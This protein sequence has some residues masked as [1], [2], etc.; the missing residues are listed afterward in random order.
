M[1]IKL[2]AATACLMLL[3][4]AG[5]AQSLKIGYVKVE[6]LFAEWP[7]TKKSNTELQE[8]EELL[9]SRLQAKIQ[10]FQ[11]KYAAYQ[12]NA[13]TMDAVTR[14]DTETELQNL[15]TQI[16][17][18]ESN[19]QQS[20]AEKNSALIKPLQDKMRTTIDQVAK[21]NGYSH[22]FA[23]GT[24]LVF[25]TDKAGDIT[26]KVAQKLGFTLSADAQ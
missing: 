13:G 9:S 22:V 16:Q 18:Y 10:D 1:K 14:Q 8:Y 7:D 11:T 24:A 25:T 20:I 23:Y 6:K 17:Q 26:P 15:Q 3:S 5:Q 12:K 2:F 4:F 19:A 21:E